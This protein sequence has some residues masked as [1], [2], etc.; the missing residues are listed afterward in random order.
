[1]NK[2]HERITQMKT[3]SFIYGMAG[4][5]TMVSACGVGFALYQNVR[6]KTK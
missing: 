3:V 5:G 6:P 1:M 4:W 2:K